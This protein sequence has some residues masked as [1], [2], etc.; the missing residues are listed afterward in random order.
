MKALFIHIPKTAGTSIRHTLGVHQSKKV[1]NIPNALDHNLLSFGHISTSSL[2]RSG[3]IESE[4]V[5]QAFVFT[6][7]RNPFDRAV[8]LWAHLVDHGRF[9]GSFSSYCKKIARTKDNVG[10]F[11]LRRLSQASSQHAWIDGVN[12]DFVGK[13]EN[14]KE[15]FSTVC[16]LL[17]M[18]H[19]PK[20]G[21]MRIGKHNDWRT[22][23][24]RRLE[25]LIYDRYEQD[26]KQFGYKER[27]K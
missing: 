6:F 19:V 2:I 18:D 7:V 3:V 13:Y 25:R 23:Y 17:G 12:L 21:R 10:L 27:I 11:N 16:G 15:D 4:A 22:Y 1:K 20:I 26:F 24:N 8:S 5:E 14:L 9:V